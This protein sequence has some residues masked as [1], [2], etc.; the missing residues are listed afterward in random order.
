MSASPNEFSQRMM[1]YDINV[2]CN[3]LT[4]QSCSTSSNDTG[5]PPTHVRPDPHILRSWNIP[6]YGDDCVSSEAS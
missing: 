6:Q 2:L 1:L 5:H 4:N 3:E